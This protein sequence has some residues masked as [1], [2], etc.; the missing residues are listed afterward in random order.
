MW[1]GKDLKDTI[2][3]SGIL[4]A[5]KFVGD[6]SGLTNVTGTGGISDASWAYIEDISGTHI[7]NSS[8]AVLIDKV[9]NASWAYIE[10]ISSAYYTHA[11]NVS[12]P[13]AVT[14]S[15]L[16]NP[17]TNTVFSMA[18][19]TLEF[20]YTAPVPGAASGAFEIEATGDFNGDL[21]HIHQ[22]T[23]NPG[24][25]TDAV[26]IEVSDADVMQL[27]CTGVTNSLTIDANTNLY[28]TANISGA[29]IRG[30]FASFAQINATSDASFANANVTGR[31][32][33]A[34]L[35]MSSQ[36]SF[37]NVNA[38]ATISGGFI[39]VTNDYTTVSSAYVAN[40]VIGTAATPPTASNFTQGTIY[41]QYTP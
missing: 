17:T 32:S 35:I 39:V 26:H 24:A 15:Q 33:G 8:Y 31:I 1:E 16:G 13:H 27:R 40:I 41:V 38:S 11:N 20:K 21:L 22:H 19:K 37:A 34:N 29:N 14:L 7:N 5:E 23:G 4:Q 25:G 12:N 3:W 28:S 30:G 10:G 2:K 18:N 6:G 9:P 36:V